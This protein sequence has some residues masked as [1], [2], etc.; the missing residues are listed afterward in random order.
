MVRGFQVACLLVLFA[1]CSHSQTQAE[2]A[3]VVFTLDFPA[4]QPAHTP[5]ECNR[6]ARRTTS[7]PAR[8]LPSLNDTDSFDYDFILSAATRARIFELSAKAGY[9]EKDLDSH[10]KNMAFTGQQ[11]AQLQRRRPPGAS[12][13]TTTRPV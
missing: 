8:F 1:A 10:R 7:R 12:P 5:C 2:P 11:D 9:F 4:S 3:T 6:T 13:P